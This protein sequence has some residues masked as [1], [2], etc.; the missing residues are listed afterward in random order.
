MERPLRHRPLIG[1][2]ILIAGIVGLF[3]L[4][5]F[6]LL[7]QP[8]SDAGADSLQQMLGWARAGLFTAGAIAF[9]V[10]LAISLRGPGAPPERR[11]SLPVEPEPRRQPA[12]FT[13]VALGATPADTRAIADATSADE[14]IRLLWE[15]SEEHPEE[16]VVL[17]NADAEPVAF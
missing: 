2:S 5:A 14:A 6:S 10:G 12:A 17:F 4:L 11:S 13:L 15:W 9:L 7:I 3:G 1:S 16:R 8:P